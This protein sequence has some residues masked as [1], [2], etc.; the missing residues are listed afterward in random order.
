M[1]SILMI[2]ANISQGYSCGA[3]CK[4]QQQLPE[5]KKL[6]L[7]GSQC[8]SNDK[9]KLIENTFQLFNPFLHSS[10]GKVSLKILING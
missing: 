3:N 1:F 7:R 5:K 10:V 2:N 9:I 4:K 6:P 8:I